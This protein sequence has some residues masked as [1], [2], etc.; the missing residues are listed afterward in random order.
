MPTS[1]KV[2]DR[3]FGHN[4]D[5][6]NPSGLDFIDRVHTVDSKLILSGKLKPTQMIAVMI[7]K[8]T[9]KYTNLIDPILT[10]D[11]CVRHT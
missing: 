9:S 1:P 3:P 6:N 7:K 4:F 5:I 10:P 2:R 11:Y 8:D